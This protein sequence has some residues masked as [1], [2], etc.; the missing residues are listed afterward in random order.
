MSEI[1][2]KDTEETK[3]T[4]KL[5]QGLPKPKAMK[6]MPWLRP[7]TGLFSIVSGLMYVVAAAII[8]I[9]TK[10]WGMANQF[11]KELETG[12]MESGAATSENAAAKAQMLVD[13]YLFAA[14]RIGSLFPFILAFL[15]CFSMLVVA[16]GV[17]LLMKKNWSINVGRLACLGTIALIFVLIVFHKGAYTDIADRFDRVDLIEEFQPFGWMAAIRYIFL[18]SMCPIVLIIGQGAIV[19]Q[20]RKSGEN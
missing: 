8:Y 14:E 1:D 10:F 18:C 19:K 15:A 11:T 16:S 2:R 17:G 6:L 4:E 13:A 9:F 12:L 3:V 5:G 7:L 20:S